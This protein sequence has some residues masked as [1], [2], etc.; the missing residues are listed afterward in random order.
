MGP[1]T[2]PVD[3]GGQNPRWQRVHATQERTPPA[4]DVALSDTPVGP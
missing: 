2:R 4:V 1:L 3:V